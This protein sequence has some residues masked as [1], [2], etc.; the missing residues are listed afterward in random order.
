M[1]NSQQIYNQYLTYYN[2][3]TADIYAI[4]QL[5][6]SQR[7]QAN[8]VQDRATIVAQQALLGTIYQ[9]D[10][11]TK[12]LDQ[13]VADCTT[14]VNTV[15]AAYTNAMGGSTNPYSL[16]IQQDY[17]NAQTI[18]AQLVSTMDGNETIFSS[19]SSLQATLTSLQ[20][21]I[22]QMPAGPAQLKAQQD[23]NAANAALTALTKAITTAGPQFTVLQGQLASI[24]N[25]GGLL[26]QLDALASL[27]NPTVD[28]LDQANTLLAT[29]QGVQT[30][31]QTFQSGLMAAVSSAYSTELA[32]IQT[33]KTDIRPT[34]PPPAPGTVEHSTWMPLWTYNSGNFPVPQGVTLVNLFV[35]GL[36]V[37]GSGNPALGALED[38]TLPLLS[39]FVS[40]CQ[41]ANPP[42]AVKLSIGGSGGLYGNCWD[43]LTAD[44][45]SAYATLLVNFCHTYG[46]VGIDFDYEEF[47]ST[48]QEQ[49]VGQLIQQFK[50]QDSNLQTS[51][52]TNAGFG[53]QYPW[54]AVVQTICDASK[55]ASGQCGVDKLYIMSYTDPLSQEEP[56]IDGWYSWMN[57]TYGFTPSQIGVGID[58]FDSNSYDIGQFAA[59]IAQTMHL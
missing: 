29:I 37:D 31:L 9:A 14:V 57:T 11:S 32:D 50:A 34:P 2:A 59:K 3:F 41:A 53:T 15:S 45:I 28:D 51:L 43:N 7:S 46:L 33:V 44:N 25:S 55:N 5:P 48:N 13:F 42:V 27:S 30:A 18:A 4:D 16:P 24:E 58:N 39:Q 12:T 36:T 38:M 23:W 20:T 49:L 26:D 17:A 40:D 10:Y 19:P 8:V 21:Q 56:W 52:C 35:G 1:S 47:K 6:Y 22:N 54:Q